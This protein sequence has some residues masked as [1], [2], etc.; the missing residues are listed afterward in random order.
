MGTLEHR[1][2]A[3]CSLIAQLFP[4]Q[5]EVVLHDLKTGKIA[6]IEGGYSHR[7][8]GDDSLIDLEELKADAN[9]N[10]VIGPYPQTSWDSE[11]LRS[12]TAILQD[13]EGRPNGLVCVNTRTSAFSAAA[14][15]LASFSHMEEAPKPKALF[16]R[17]WRVAANTLIAQ[18][19]AERGRTLVTAKRQ[20]KV[21]LL[22]ALDK[23]GILEMRGSPEYAAKALGMSRA[24]VYN[25]LKDARDPEKTDTTQ[26]NPEAA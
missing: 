21:A 9:D 16:E 20:D 11:I 14:N 19:L 1:Y 15:L 4:G 2:G 6:A 17:D 12:F 26:K 24:S 22:G 23:A 3:V 8:I 25:L 18:T 10:D 5:I 13:D 7:V